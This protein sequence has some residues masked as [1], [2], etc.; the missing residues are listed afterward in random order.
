[1]LASADLRALRETQ[2][3]TEHF[4]D[5]RRRRSQSIGL[6]SRSGNG[7]A[8]QEVLNCILDKSVIAK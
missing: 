3:D 1:M 2:Q 6:A 5:G 8:P 7:K 4:D